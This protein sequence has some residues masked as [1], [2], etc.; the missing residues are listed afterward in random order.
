MITCAG[1]ER[2]KVID[3]RSSAQLSLGPVLTCVSADGISGPSIA[4]G[5]ATNN[6]RDKM[7]LTLSRVLL[8]QPLCSC[9]S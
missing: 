8:A 2:A 4:F 6:F 5:Q 7:A 9:Q 1:N 3:P